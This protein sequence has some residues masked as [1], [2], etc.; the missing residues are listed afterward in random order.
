MQ[1]VT[2]P[3]VGCTTVYA[4]ALFAAVLAS[5]APCK[6]G[7]LTATFTPVAGSAGA[8]NIS[9][10]LR[11]RNRSGR[12]CSV[13]GTPVLRLLDR[14]NRPLP[15]YSFSEQSGTAVLVVLRPGRYSA[16]VARFSPDIAGPG[17]PITRQCEPAAYSVRVLVPPD[18]ANAV[19]RVRPPT[20][21]CEHGRMSVSVFVPGRNAPGS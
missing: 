15:S 8:G 3:L 9:Y 13:A 6:S 7:A 1:D 21:V 14:R 17:E 2:P 10:V 4:A 19:A 20:P 11:I 16:A 18:D 5:V 12:A